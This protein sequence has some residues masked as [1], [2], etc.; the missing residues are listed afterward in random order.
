MVYVYIV[1]LALGS[2]KKQRWT[3]YKVYGLLHISGPHLLAASIFWNAKNLGLHAAQRL[4]SS[5]VCTLAMLE[6]VHL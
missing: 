2:R 3:R 1:L 4:I 6:N 5:L